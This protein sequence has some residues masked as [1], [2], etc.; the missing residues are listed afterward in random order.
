MARGSGTVTVSIIGKAESLVT[1][2]GDSEKGLKG[3]G[4]KLGTAGKRMSTFVTVPI[5]GF[6]GVA[7]TAATADADAQA[8]LATTL[9]NTVDATD[10]VIAAVEKQITAF[11]DV[12]TFSD[13]E[14]RPAFEDLVRVTGSVS[15][16][17]DLMAVAMDVAAAKGIPL[18]TA[19]KAVAKASEG[20]FTAVNKLVPGLID[21]SDK[22]LTADD[23]MAA[24]AD[25]FG[26]EAQAAMETTGGKAKVAARDMGE[27]TESLGVA[28]I[29]ILTQLLDIVQ[30]VIDKFLAMDDST[31]KIIVVIGLAVAAIGPLITVIG[32]LSTAFTF[33][34]ANPI[35][36]VI[37]ALVALGVG[38]VIAY[39]K[40]ETFRDI[41]NAAVQAVANA[42]LDMGGWVLDV[43][44]KMLGGFATMVEAASHLPVVGSKFAGMADDIR[45]AQHAVQDM[46]DS[47]HTGIN[48][49]STDLDKAR[50]GFRDLGLAATNIGFGGGGGGIIVGAG[51]VRARAAGGPVSA[52][53]PYLVGED[54]PE[55]FVPGRSGT[56]VPNVGG[57]GVT[58][59]VSGAL[60][61]TAVARQIS[62]LLARA[63]AR[64]A[65]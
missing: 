37:A 57:G 24:L 30:P 27:L 40:S 43:I 11:M 48:I 49:V 16:A 45:G 50:Q 28:L 7:A 9:R 4:D 59:N 42:F 56:I 46:A 53:R 55:L 18:E 19:V 20:Q 36:L 33:L 1:A 52:G 3:L 51:P 41:V 47:M 32:A 29:P 10:A 23:A 17:N 26:G 64:G 31:Q 44:D 62:D 15:E 38:L 58:I 34:A 22:S 63:T 60:D 21:L 39:Q 6:L 54:R 14:L 12:S 61:P 25:T 5:V 8:G 2:L 35:V 13:D 65:I